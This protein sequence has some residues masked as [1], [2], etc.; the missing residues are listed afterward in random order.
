MMGPTTPTRPAPAHALPAAAAPCDSPPPTPPPA[1]PQTSTSSLDDS[2]NSAGSPSYWH[3]STRRKPNL[4]LTVPQ[5]ESPPIQR[6]L[7][8]T[9]GDPFGSP[10]VST[11]P[12]LGTISTSGGGTASHKYVESPASKGAVTPTS[13]PLTPGSAPRPDSAESPWLSSVGTITPSPTPRKL[14]ERRLTPDQLL[15]PVAPLLSPVPVAIDMPSPSFDPL[16]EH[17]LRPLDEHT[18][19][20]CVLERAARGKAFRMLLEDG[21]VLLLLAERRY[22]DF[23][24]A[25]SDGSRIATLHRAHHGRFVLRRAT[26]SG[27]APPELAAIVLD[28]CEVANAPSRPRMNH[29]RLVAGQCGTPPLG[30][31]S[32]SAEM[33]RSARPGADDASA[34]AAG[35]SHVI[36]GQIDART[37]QIDLRSPRSSS[38]LSIAMDGLALAQS[39]AAVVAAGLGGGPLYSR[40]IGRSAGELLG[41]LADGAPPPSSSL[42]VLESRLP[43]WDENASLLT[44]DFPP[45]RASLASVQNFQL[46]PLGS[47]AAAAAAAAAQDSLA[48]SAALVHGLIGEAAGL[49]TFSLDVRPPLSPLLAFAAC[50]AA[51]D[52]A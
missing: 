11:P 48:F 44:L 4:K 26:M 25:A 33:S 8:R 29:M 22:R 14:L 47:E 40:A 43:T 13:R 28:E 35:E 1:E 36:T 38:D 9:Y 27:T 23:E 39:E 5:P 19:C 41:A 52:W 10:C 7:P 46:V 30:A 20:A 50:L 6:L 42:L 15:S 32:I 16:L 31:L 24:I 12:P 2:P 51:Q 17:F 3:A 37:G 49:D 45:D 34:T 18:M 21:N